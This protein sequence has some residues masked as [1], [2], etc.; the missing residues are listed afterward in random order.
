MASSDRP[1]STCSVRCNLLWTNFHLKGQKGIQAGPFGP[2]D[3]CFHSPVNSLSCKPHSV[4]VITKAERQLSKA[5]KSKP[6]DLTPDGIILYDGH[7]IFCSRWVRFVI[8]RDPGAEFRFLAVQT[9]Q[10]RALA[11]KLGIDPDSP[12]T[13]AVVLAGRAYFKSEA[14]LQVLGRLPGWSWVRGLAL[15]PR[16]L[17][18][19]VY[20]RVAGNRHRLFGRSESCLILPPEIARRHI[21]E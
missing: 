16:P 14:A 3:R 2:L 12:E 5:W 4:P 13:N 9:E 7:C 18:D 1:I 15:V 17:R 19:W 20:D 8:K 21:M 11:A 6:V 10:G